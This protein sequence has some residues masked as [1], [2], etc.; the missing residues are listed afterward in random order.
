MSTA[1]RARSNAR[2]YRPAPAFSR[3]ARSSR[4]A[5]ASSLPSVLR[6]SILSIA[7]AVSRMSSR[8]FT[9]PSGTDF[10]SSSTGSG[11]SWLSSTDSS[12]CSAGPRWASAICNV[13]CQKSGR[14][15]SAATAIA[16]A[17]APFA[18]AAR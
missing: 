8:P 4:A 11:V 2:S 1:S 13:I 12:A 10:Q 9:C 17:D 15:I 14:S 18:P 16:F 6:C 7:S 3:E 5:R